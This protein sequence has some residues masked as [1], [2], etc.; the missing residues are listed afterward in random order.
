MRKNKSIGIVGYGFVGKAVSQIQKVHKTEIYDPA[1]QQYAENFE[2]FRQ[3]IVFVCVPTPT[4]RGEV[5]LSYVEDS[6]QKWNDLKSEDSIL[7]LKSTIPAGTTDYFC[8]KYGTNNIVH[9]PEFL[10]QRTANQDFLNPLEVIIGGD[11]SCC[12]RVAGLYKDF[13]NLHSESAA[14]IQ[15]FSISSRQA[16]LLKTVRNSFYATKVSFFNEVYDLCNALDIEYDS[17]I[18]VFTLGGS[19]PWVGNQHVF[20]PGPDGKL[21]FAGACLPKDSEGLL[22][23]SKKRGVSMLV[24][25]AAIKTNKRRIK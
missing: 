1:F 9:N 18:N 23:L 12:D 13:Y 15:Y 10:T 11:K 2:A 4:E 6:A 17:F 8:E 3:D 19:H 16:E 22:N 5:I 14:E 20:V 24:L 7:V 21:G 25:E